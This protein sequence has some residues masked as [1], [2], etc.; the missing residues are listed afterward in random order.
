MIFVLNHYLAQ[1]NA[2]KWDNYYVLYLTILSLPPLTILSFLNI[3]LYT[4][5]AIYLSVQQ[6]DGDGETNDKKQSS[7]ERFSFRRISLRSQ[8][9]SENSIGDGW[10]EI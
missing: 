2:Q 1:L 4:F 10:R 9:I 8:W 6:N 5:F 3:Y 7:T